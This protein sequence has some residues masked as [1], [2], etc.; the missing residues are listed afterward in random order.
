MTSGLGSEPQ[1]W[2][3]KESLKTV[4]MLRVYSEPKSLAKGRLCFI[5]AKIDTARPQGHCIFNLLECSAVLFEE[6]LN[7]GKPVL[8]W[9]SLCLDPQCRLLQGHMGG[10][11]GRMPN[12]APSV[13]LFRFRF[14]TTPLGVLWPWGVD[15]A[16]ILSDLKSVSVEEVT[17]I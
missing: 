10:T 2:S 7:L 16:L 8:A 14:Y 1:A 9:I 17:F 4:E 3:Y 6:Y 11:Q 13:I 15:P 12:S 5:W